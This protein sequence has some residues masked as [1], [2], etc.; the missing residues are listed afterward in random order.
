MQRSISR[1]LTV[2]FLRAGCA[3]SREPSAPRAKQQAVISA[4]SPSQ[5]LD[6]LPLAERLMHEASDQP[7]ARQQVA[8]AFARFR[9]A[10]VTLTRTR[11]ALARPLRAQYCET[12]LTAG[13]LALALCAF[14]DQE[15]ALRGRELSQRS[16]DALIPGRTLLV[17]EG[18]LLT[19]TKPAS[20]RARDEVARIH[21]RFTQAEP[22]K[23]HAAL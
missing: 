11:Q 7:E 6:P 15:A 16:F 3:Q 8:L 9:E 17:Q 13:G 4:A 10:G 23:E 14:P 1:C 5:E 21:A 20:D 2:L 12:G 18:N 22:F 19:I